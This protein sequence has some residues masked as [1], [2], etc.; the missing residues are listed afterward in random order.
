MCRMHSPGA[1]LAALRLDES[2]VRFRLRHHKGTD[3]QYIHASPLEAIDGFF[4]SAND[5]FILVET[6]VENYRDASP[7]MKG[8]YQ[9]V[10]QRILLA[11]HSLQTSGAIHMIDGA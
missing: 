11:S 6:G 8:R 1:M 5:G 2:Q 7:S 3:C 9:I 10:V 4:G